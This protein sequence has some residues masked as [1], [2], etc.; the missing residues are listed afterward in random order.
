MIP[1]NPTD[2]STAC[3]FH[4][5]PT[6]ATPPI[7]SNQRITK[8]SCVADILLVCTFAYTTCYTANN[9]NEMGKH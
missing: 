9:L 3:Y 2:H 4:S 8:F 7:L 1:L 6:L 5:P